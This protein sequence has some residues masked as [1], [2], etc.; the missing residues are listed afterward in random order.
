MKA[1]E[2][3]ENAG[4]DLKTVEKPISSVTGTLLVYLRMSRSWWPASRSA[5]RAQLRFLRYRW[6]IPGRRW[7]GRWW[8]QWERF[9]TDWESSSG[10]FYRHSAWCSRSPAARRPTEMR[11][12]CTRA[13]FARS[14]AWAPASLSSMLRWCSRSTEEGEIYSFEQIAEKRRATH[15]EL[16]STEVVHERR[17]RLKLFYC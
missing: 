8:G 3:N 5:P 13:P 16:R 11:K 9:S 6:H 1:I 15:P 17:K 2:V 10:C 7:S 12:V 14:R 4:E